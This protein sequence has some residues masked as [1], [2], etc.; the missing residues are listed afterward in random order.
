MR[1]ALLIGRLNIGGAERQFLELAQGLGA[2]GHDV[3]LFTIYRGGALAHGVE[4]TRLDPL[5]NMERG[6]SPK[7]LLRAV[8]TLRSRLRLHRFDVA[9]SALYLTNLMNGLAAPRCGVPAVWGIRTADEQLVWKERVPMWLGK[10]MRGRIAGTICNSEAGL[11][12]NRRWRY[13][14][15][16]AVVI[17]NGIRTDRYRPDPVARR[18]FR[19]S[20]GYSDGDVLVGLVGRPSPLKGDELFVRAACLAAAREERLRFV[21]VIPSAA[22]AGAQPDHIASPTNLNG[23][24]RWIEGGDSVEAIYP[25]LDLL[26]SA[27]KVE[28]FS[29]VIGEGMASGLPAIVTDVGDSAAIVA[30]T[31]AV[32]H[33]GDAEALARS[34]VSLAVLQPERRHALG[35]RARRRIEELYSVEM[36]LDRTEAYLHDIAGGRR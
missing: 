27:S 20:H 33:A 28:G 11:A 4:G 12:L 2:R 26:C 31:G 6:G 34:M 21:R 17:P 15:D 13:A 36:L 18:R 8:A 14:T 25:G 5:L 35:R 22:Q 24:F 7:D 30:S 1:L 23:R 29:N 9:Y 32:V 19:V 3:T 10:L 16:N